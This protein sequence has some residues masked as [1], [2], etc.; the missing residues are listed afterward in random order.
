MKIEIIIILV[1]IISSVLWLSNRAMFSRFMSRSKTDR[2]SP[3]DM[4]RNRSSWSTVI[5]EWEN[6][7]IPAYPDGINKRFF[8]E[9]SMCDRSMSRPYMHTFIES[10]LLERYG[11][12]NYSAYRNYLEDSDDKNV[13]AF[14]NLSGDA[15]LVVPQP[16]S[17]KNYVTLKDFMDNAPQEQQV[18]FWKRA[19]QEIRRWLNSG[20]DGK[21][22]VFVSTHGLGIPYFHLRLCKRPK[23]YKTIEFKVTV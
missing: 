3:S 4:F 9:T 12:H 11:Q 21:N 8:F 20:E 16:R 14:N 13:V 7:V 2:Y 1:V 19:A 6:G 15:V 5:S 18:A 10:D 23:Y 22:V 17:G